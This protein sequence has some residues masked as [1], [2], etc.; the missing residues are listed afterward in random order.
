MG[1][2]ESHALF[3]EAL[4]YHGSFSQAKEDLDR[5]AESL[6]PY[7][8]RAYA[9]LGQA[10]EAALGTPQRST[11]LRQFG[12]AILGC[13]EHSEGIKQASAK[14]AEALLGANQKLDEGQK[15][16]NSSPLN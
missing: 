10:K 14:M 11:Y 1:I 2:H 7:L 9:V 13:T 6:F 16:L 12:K 4:K 8:E 3:T 15:A 5:A